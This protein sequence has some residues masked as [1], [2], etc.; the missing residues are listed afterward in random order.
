[1]YPRFAQD[2][3]LIRSRPFAVAENEKRKFAALEDSA[4]DQMV[5]GDFEAAYGSIKEMM[6]NYPSLYY[7]L[8]SMP[9]SY[10]VLWNRNP[11]P[12]LD[13]DWNEYV[14]RPEVRGALHVGR[15]G[16]ASVLTVFDRLK[17]DIPRSVSGW[18]AALLDAGR[19][20][21]LLYS[22]HLDV[23]VPYRSTVRVARALRWS[24]ADMFANATRTVWRVP[25]TTES[26]AASA[27]HCCDVTDVAGYATA[28]GPLTVLMIRNAGHMASY[29]Q[30][31]WA[32][33]MIVRFTSGKPFK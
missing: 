22:G 23:I 19:Y 8:T 11:I 3:R 7:N 20:R 17:Y 30:P 13:G 28:Y 32:H 5:A 1:M 27:D 16:W 25:V 29:D 10:N 4:R 26:V 9:T 18:L 2:L 12:Y 15:R 33:E 24:G 6:V 21:V 14:Q 31:A